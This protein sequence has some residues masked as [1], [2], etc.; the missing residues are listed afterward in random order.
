MEYVHYTMLLFITTFTIS[1][2][3]NINCVFSIDPVLHN[4]N[5]KGL[6]S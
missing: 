2:S 3:F 5:T 4:F 1:W 6:N